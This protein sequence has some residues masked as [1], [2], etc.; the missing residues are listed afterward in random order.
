MPEPKVKVVVFMGSP[1][2]MAHCEKIRTVCKTYGIP[3]D[4]RVSSAHK[5]SLETLQILAQYEG[6]LSQGLI[7]YDY[8]RFLF[9]HECVCFKLKNNHYE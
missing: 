1:S 7:Y 6:I 3:C 8:F 4:L 2:D 9:F 5:A